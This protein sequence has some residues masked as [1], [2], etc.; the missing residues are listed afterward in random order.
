MA[1]RD[2]KLDLGVVAVAVANADSVVV[3]R[4]V[5]ANA[6]A[7]GAAAFANADSVVVVRNVAANA[8][9]IY[10]DAAGVEDVWCCC[11]C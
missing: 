10:A 4:N 6:V 1:S 11:R 5:A 2:C 9:C 8:D 3:V 7:L